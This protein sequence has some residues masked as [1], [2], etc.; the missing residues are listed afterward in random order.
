MKQ[1]FLVLFLFAPL[2]V[3]YAQDFASGIIPY[4]GEIRLQGIK[5]GTGTILSYD[6]HVFIVTAKHVLAESAG[7]IF[8]YTY[9]ESGRPEEKGNSIRIDINHDVLTDQLYF[10]DSFDIAVIHIGF[11]VIVPQGQ[12]QQFR[13]YSNIVDVSGGCP[14]PAFLD[15][16][17]WFENHLELGID[18][19]TM[20]F[21]SELDRKDETK[22]SV[23]KG[24][25]SGFYPDGRLKLQ[26]PVFGGNSGGPVIIHGSN[27]PS[28]YGTNLIIGSKRAFIA[29]IVTELVPLVDSSV[30][31]RG[32]GFILS[33]NSGFAKAEPIDRV[34]ALIKNKILKTTKK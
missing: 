7:K 5:L 11:P 28:D 17:L 13:F 15:N 12:S 25:L 30:S 24:V 2:S 27:S 21:P 3:A 20:G 9:Y 31:Q 22:V 34:V 29:G 10:S 26:L 19:L 16:M 4:T 33:T 14:L 6:G 23:V 8:E 32:S 1:L 18:I